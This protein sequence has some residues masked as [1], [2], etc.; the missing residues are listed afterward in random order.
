VINVRKLPYLSLWVLAAMLLVATGATTRAARAQNGEPSL[1]IDAGID[2]NGPD[3]V[4]RIED[5][6][7]VS[8]GETFQIDMVIQDVE[9]L[10]AWEASLDFDP[11]VVTVV[12]HDV[13]Q[14]QEVN[15][16][17]SVIDISSQVPDDSGFH[18]LSAFESSDPPQVDTG[19]GVLA[20]LTLEAQADGQSLLR[21]GNRDFNQD[22]VQDRGV[23][24]KDIDAD[25]IGDETGDDFFDGER[26][27]AMVA[28]GEDCPDGS[29]PAQ[30]AGAGDNGSSG[31]MIAGGIAAGIALAVVAL[32]AVL[33][34]RRRGAGASP[35]ATEA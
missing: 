3:A 27:D 24:L 5:C 2:G 14:F 15:A 32:G 34:L 22:G 31:L 21:F 1:A 25:V 11:A 17:S 18:T 30:A 7:S 35:G 28:V 8:P 19:S 26:Q 10:L 16:G 33:L 13:K 20:R 6:I 29:T 12:G 23:L 4:G 9:E